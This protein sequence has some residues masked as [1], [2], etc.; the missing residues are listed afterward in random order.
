MN[1]KVTQGVGRSFATLILAS[2]L[3]T[4]GC[5]HFSNQPSSNENSETIVDSPKNEEINYASF[6]QDQ[7]TLY[8]LLVAEIAGQRNRIDITLVNYIQQ[9]RSTRDPGVIR[10]ALNAAQYAKD[11][12]A[13]KELALLW[14]DVEPENPSPYQLLAYHY[15]LSK[16]YAQ[17]IENIDTVIALG[18]RISVESLAIG[19]QSLPDEDKQLLLELY[20]RLREKH[21]DSLPVQ[22]SLAIVQTHLGDKTSALENLEEILAKD[23]DF[24]SAYVLKSNI[25]LD[26]SKEEAEAFVSKA[27]ERYPANH[28]LGRI[29]ASLLIN[30]KELATAADIFA[31]LM[32]RYPQTP[33]FQLSYALVLLEDKRVDESRENLEQL[34]EA[35]VHQNE[36]HFYLG[37][38]ADTNQELDKAVYHYTSI[39]G[40]TH[41]QASLERAA[42]LLIQAERVEEGIDVLARARAKHPDQAPTLWGLQYKLL[43]S[44]EDNESA[45]ATLNEALNEF[46]ENE[47][48]LYARAM[49]FERENQLDAMEQDLRKIMAINPQNAVAMNALGYTLADRTDRIDEAYQLVAMALNLKPEN[50][51]V[52]DSMGWVLFKKGQNEQALLFLLNAF[53]K[54]NDGEIGA[55]LGEVLLSLNQTTEAHEIWTRSFQLNPEH[56]VLIKTLQRLAPD[57][58]LELETQLEAF[59]KEALVPQPDSQISDDMAPALESTTIETQE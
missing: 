29:Y 56:P 12:E 48:L 10:R 50:P 4:S 23:E 44:L 38:I 52:M 8:D 49:H 13:I 3:G 45:K 14:K 28:T 59:E 27:Y 22:Y 5:A 39:A 42:Y 40:G 2:V 6:D 35:G 33:A 21:P 16:D 15:S 58:L 1:L 26:K 30:R 54:F 19:S 55:H 36:A 47:D 43:N 31:D 11:A 53:Q 20:Q 9:A 32:K 24:E 51:A 41:Q 25:L 7:D 37:R 18:G 34:L 46:P 17:A 57:L